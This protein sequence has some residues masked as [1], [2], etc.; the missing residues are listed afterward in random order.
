MELAF[1][2]RKGDDNVDIVM[3]ENNILNKL[4]VI[5]DVSERR[6]GTC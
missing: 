6:L 2:Q 4:I 1:F 5:D 3:D